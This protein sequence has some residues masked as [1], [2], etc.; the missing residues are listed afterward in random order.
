MFEYMK[1]NTL[2]AKNYILPSVLGMTVLALAIV[3]ALLTP[4]DNQISGINGFVEGLSGQSSGLLGNIQLFGPLG[5]SFA[6]GMIA[7][8]NPCGFPMLPAYMGLYLG[9]DNQQREPVKLTFRIAR[10]LIVGQVV[11]AGFV[12]LFGITGIIIGFGIHSIRELIPWFGLSIGF[13]LTLAGS[14]LLAGGG[15]YS[16]FPAKIASYLGNPGQ[17]SMKGYFLFGISYGTASLSC[18]LPIFLTVV[19]STLAVS[20][21]LAATGQFLLYSM[22]MGVVIIGLTVGMALFKE[23]VV[24][25][26]RRTLPYIGLLSSIFMITAGAYI[27]FYWLTLG[28]L[29]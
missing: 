21:T 23:T 3:G 4:E 18:T 16:G 22:G 12:L 10:A 6:A 14:W 7:T 28:D 2:P 19:A 8:V 27:V 15:I 29:I 25:L 1:Q 5:F 26:L 13:F 20:G 17:V 24:G 11:T 9:S